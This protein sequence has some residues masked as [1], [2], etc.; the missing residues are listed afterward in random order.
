M[1]TQSEALGAWINAELDKRVH[2]DEIPVSVIVSHAM[3]TRTLAG[4]RLYKTH[5]EHWIELSFYDG[6]HMTLYD[7]EEP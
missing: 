5:G 2:A 4:T 6:S 1:T 7:G 3:R